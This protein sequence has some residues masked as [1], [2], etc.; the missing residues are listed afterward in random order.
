M[1]YCLNVGPNK[2]AEFFHMI[3]LKKNLNIFLFI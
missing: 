1:A 3:A 2:K